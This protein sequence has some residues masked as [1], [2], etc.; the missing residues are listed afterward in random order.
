MIILEKAN[1]HCTDEHPYTLPRCV[2]GNHYKT[3][4]WFYLACRFHRQCEHRIHPEAPSCALW[5]PAVI[6]VPT[7]PHGSAIAA[8]TNIPAV[9]PSQLLRTA[10]WYAKTRLYHILCQAIPILAHGCTIF[11][12]GH[13]MNR[14]LDLDMTTISRLPASHQT[15]P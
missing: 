1:T 2:L 4:H 12:G 5:V 9:L 6:A 14:S 13:S 7:P 8:S 11:M 3:V 10:S 15:K